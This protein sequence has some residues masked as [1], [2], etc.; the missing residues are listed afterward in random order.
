MLREFDHDLRRN[1]V[2]GGLREVV[3]DDWKR[4]PVGDETV[5]RHH[6]LR[7][8]LALVE[9]WSPDHGCVVVQAGGVFNQTERLGGG[10]KTTSGDHHFLGS[11]GCNRNAHHFPFFVVAEHNG[12]AAR[13]LHNDSAD[14][15]FRITIYIVLELFVVHLPIRV[16]RRGD[17]RKNA[18]QKHWKSLL[19]LTQG[20][21]L[22]SE[23]TNGIG[24]SLD[25]A[26]YDYQK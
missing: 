23:M 5:V 6:I 24:P 16:E 22:S 8:Q 14:R 12:F 10:L 19:G 21:Q 1:V 7:L 13:T 9:V 3:D 4:G 26:N 17:G 25:L 18:I 11:R 20:Y 15:R 2:P